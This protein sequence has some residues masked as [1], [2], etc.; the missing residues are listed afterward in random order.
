MAY[1]LILLAVVLF[2]AGLWLLRPET[3]LPAL[4]VTESRQAWAKA[5]GFAYAK[6][7]ESLT[8]EWRRGAASA[9]AAATKVASGVQYGHDTYIADLGSTTVIAMTTGEVSDVVVDMRR[10][11]N[12]DPGVGA[13]DNAGTDLHLVAELEGFRVF[14]TDT[15]PI[16]RFID[17]RVSTAL[18]QMPAAVE[19]VWFEADWVVAQMAHGA[20]TSDWHAAFA[21]LGLLAD[22]ARTLPPA[23]PRGLAERGFE[24]GVDKQKLLRPEVELPTRVTGTTKGEVDPRE[25][26]ADDVAPIAG[27]SRAGDLTRAPR[28]QQ[29]PSIFEEDTHE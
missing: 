2:A 9:G 22:A 5:H 14:G 16:Q 11:D 27:D 7:D 3:S 19:A 4:P 25:V 23:S 10:V 17:V 28:M 12:A 6:T 24:V 20:K 29:P 13:C 26:G 18:E 21:P 1:V 8:G 15:G